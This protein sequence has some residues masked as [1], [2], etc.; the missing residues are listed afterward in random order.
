MFGL[1]ILGHMLN[2][3]EHVGEILECVWNKLA[4]HVRIGRRWKYW[5]CLER[6]FVGNYFSDLFPFSIDKF[7][8]GK[9]FWIVYSSPLIWGNVGG[10]L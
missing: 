7:D 6:C 4:K 5:I 10:F 3:L 9:L 2:V 1:F 8:N